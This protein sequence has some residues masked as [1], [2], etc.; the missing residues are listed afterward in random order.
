MEL[1]NACEEHLLRFLEEESL[2]ALAHLR[3]KGCPAAQSEDLLNDLA[4]DLLIKIRAGRSFLNSSD[5]ADFCRYTWAA[6][7][8]QGL[9]WR[10][11]MATTPAHS[12]IEGL[13]LASD[14]SPLELWYFWLRFPECVET[15]VLALNPKLRAVAMLHFCCP[16]E[17]VP[18][19]AECARILGINEETVKKRLLRA[20]SQLKDHLQNEYEIWRELQANP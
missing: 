7:R 4:L 8:N 14:D 16:P 2:K 9:S 1:V 12:D 18:N 17:E 6:L 20:R 11:K 13:E 10:R 5:Y 3:S 19:R 15:A